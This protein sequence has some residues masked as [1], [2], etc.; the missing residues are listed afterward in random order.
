MTN[1]RIVKKDE[2]E[3]HSDDEARAKAADGAE[4]QDRTPRDLKTRDKE[5]RVKRWAPPAMLPD[6][7]PRPGYVHRW[8]RISMVGQ[9]DNQN[10][11]MRAR[12]GWEPVRAE[13]YPEL[14]DLVDLQTTWGQRG[15]IEVGGLLLC[16]CA[17]ELM[18]QRDAHYEAQAEMQMEAVDNAL[19]RE[20]DPRMPIHRPERK[21]TTTFGKGRP[22]GG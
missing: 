2:L 9:A 1:Q 3:G 14:T 17:E 15:N 21:S 6:P 7:E 11:S 20:S 19:M 22:V 16:R 4:G 12:E 18:R 8:I 10:F 13:E 5:E